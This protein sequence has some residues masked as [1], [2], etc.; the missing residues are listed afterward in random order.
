MDTLRFTALYAALV[1]I[2]IIAGHYANR[3][4]P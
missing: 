4:W 2:C 3:R 1:G